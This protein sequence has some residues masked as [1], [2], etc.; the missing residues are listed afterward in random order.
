MPVGITTDNAHKR[1]VEIVAHEDA[2]EEAERAE[3]V[4]MFIVLRECGSCHGPMKNSFV[5][6]W[7]IQFI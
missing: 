1:P 3:K 5:S 4:G 7:L 2:Q 6:L